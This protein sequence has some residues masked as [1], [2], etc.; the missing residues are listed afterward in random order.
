MWHQVTPNKLELDYTGR[1]LINRALKHELNV[2]Y[3]T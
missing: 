2:K 3:A 1:E